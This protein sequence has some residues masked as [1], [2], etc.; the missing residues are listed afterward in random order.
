MRL[1]LKRLGTC[2]FYRSRMPQDVIQ[3]LPWGRTFERADQHSP[4]SWDDAS[5][6]LDTIWLWPRS[7]MLASCGGSCKLHVDGIDACSQL[8]RGIGTVTRLLSS[9]NVL[10]GFDVLD[11][12]LWT[13]SN[14][15]LPLKI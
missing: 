4:V 8:T 14:G 10:E 3:E 5:R 9:C 11:G 12:T 1:Q 6:F 13:L 15:V 2:S 7:L